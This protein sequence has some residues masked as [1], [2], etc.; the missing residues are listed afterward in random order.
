MK[1]YLTLLLLIFSVSEANA[2]DGF[3][4]GV[5]GI[6]S[7]TRHRFKGHND[8]YSLILNDP[9]RQKV[10]ADDVGFGGNLGYKF[11]QKDFY[12]APEIFFDYMNNK[13]PTFE[14]PNNSGEIYVRYR[15]GIRANVG[16]D[17][18]KELSAFVNYGVSMVDYDVHWPEIFAEYGYPNSYGDQTLSQIFGGGLIYNINENWSAKIA[19][20]HQ[21]SKLRYV[22]DGMYS[23]ARIE[24]ARFGFMY[25]F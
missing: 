14:V 5:D 3:Y 21:T 9:N 18:N 24:V 15:Y 2:Q 8:D 7:H 1:K 17:F 12:I 20:D 13:A 25:H 19:Y 22:Y 6:W 4:I 10:D 23:K 11:E 16:H